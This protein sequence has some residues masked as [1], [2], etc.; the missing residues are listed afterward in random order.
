MAMNP[1]QGG[2]PMGH[3]S[4]PGYPYL[5]PAYAAQH[6]A[7]AIAT[8]RAY[9]M[10]LQARGM[11]AAHIHPMMMQQPN[12]LMFNSHM[13]QR[14]NPNLTNLL[15]NRGQPGQM[16]PQHQGGQGQNPNQAEGGDPNRQ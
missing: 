2:Q 16:P 1:H 6:Q 11:H 15:Q 8:Q 5:A 7:H 3:P 12:H 14:N 13:Q 4:M 9:M 10:S